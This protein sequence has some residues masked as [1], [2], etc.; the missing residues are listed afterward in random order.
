[1]QTCGSS[2]GLL[3]GGLADQPQPGWSGI[4]VVTPSSELGADIGMASCP[5]V[6]YFE[7]HELYNFLKQNRSKSCDFDK[8]RLDGSGVTTVP[9]A[10]D[11]R[12]SMDV[13]IDFPFRA[14]ISVVVGTGHKS[15]AQ[16]KCIQCFGL[17]FLSTQGCQASMFQRKQ[18]CSVSF[19][20][21]GHR[22]V[23]T[24]RH[25]EKN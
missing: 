6:E 9:V 20:T 2:G 12:S 18:V 21:I 1:M 8:H 23:Q 16:W 19:A 14:F 4:A 17:L 15:L 24:S 11:A 7:R 25:F 5:R 22:L 13:N 10:G 3:I